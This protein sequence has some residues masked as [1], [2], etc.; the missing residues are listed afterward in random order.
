MIKIPISKVITEE[1]STKGEVEL[2]GIGTIITILMPSKEAVNPQTKQKIIVP[3]HR[4]VRMRFSE[5]YKK[6]FE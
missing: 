4:Q 6:K 1:L 2:T 5:E 3:E